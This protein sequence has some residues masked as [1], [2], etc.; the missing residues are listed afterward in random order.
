MQTPHSSGRDQ[1]AKWVA[2]NSM[3]DERGFIAQKHGNSWCYSG[4][5]E[6]ARSTF[7]VFL[8][9]FGAPAV[10]QR[11]ASPTPKH[12]E[13]A[14]DNRNRLRIGKPNLACPLPSS[15]SLLPVGQAS[16][17]TL[18]EQRNR[19]DEFVQRQA[20]VGLRLG[21]RGSACL[22]DTSASLANLPSAR[23]PRKQ[24]CQWATAIHSI[25]IWMALPCF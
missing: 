24:A 15:S 2:A 10:R 9:G 11:C 21:Q 5:N 8:Y 1:P 19:P 17:A 16:G 25:P 14:G 22:L 4:E 13:T 23:S 18:S 7:W 3:G 12:P 20:F 6:R